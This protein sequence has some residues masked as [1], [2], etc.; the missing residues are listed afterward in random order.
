MTLWENQLYA[1]FSE[2]DFVIHEV[3]LLEHVII[4]HDILV[5]PEMN[6]TVVLIPDSGLGIREIS[7]G[8]SGLHFVHFGCDCEWYKGF[9]K[10]REDLE[11]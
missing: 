5:D 11:A 9:E 7:L 10:F 6:Q 1:K 8:G 2:C 4:E 3:S